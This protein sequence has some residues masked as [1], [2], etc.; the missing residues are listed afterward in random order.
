VDSLGLPVPGA[1]VTLEGTPH[2]TSTDAAGAFRLPGVDTGAAILGVRRIGFKPAL[3][4]LQVSLSGSRQIMIT[5]AMSPEVLAPIEVEARREVYD[6]RLA[7]FVDRSR[8][9]ASGHFI[10]RERIERSHSKRLVDVLREVPSVRITTTRAWGT[11]VY[12]RGKP[13]P[14]LVF[15]DGFPASAGPFDMDMIDLATVEG[16]EVYA[17]MGGV[18]AEFSTVRGDR[19]GVVAIWSRPFRAREAAVPRPDDA[20][21]TISTMVE[22]RLAYLPESVDSV[23]ELVAGTISPA[24]PD[25]LL[26]ANVGGLVST[27]FVVD[28]SGLVELGT[29]E[30]SGPAHQLFVDAALRALREARFSPA[31]LEGRRVRQV[32]ALP[33]RFSPPTSP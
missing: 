23:A 10:T 4:P 12:L 15:I 24:Y 13:C 5:L 9:R 20:T 32:V 29:V 7:G 31:M 3:V 22:S 28:T 17:G 25:S 8:K 21:P 18:P 26:R 1:R 6:A 33:F 27:R 14:P 16:I 30:V 19:C 2:Q 11:V